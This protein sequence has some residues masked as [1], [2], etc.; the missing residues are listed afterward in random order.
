MPDEK[1]TAAP[2]DRH[3]QTTRVATTLNNESRLAGSSDRKLTPDVRELLDHL[4]HFQHRVVQDAMNEARR[5]YWL[6]RAGDFRAAL[7]RQ[8]DWHGHE[9]L[10]GV[11]R[12][13]E[14]LLEIVAACEH[15]AEVVI[16]QA[17]DD[18]AEV[19]R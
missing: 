2:K 17:V 14:R 9:G 10:A 4:T 16:W 6:R 8:S 19:D 13:R 18:E 12:R 5:S 7:P 11:R 1:R 3:S 15:A